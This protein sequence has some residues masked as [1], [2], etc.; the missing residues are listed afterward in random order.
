MVRVIV[1]SR[2]AFWLADPHYDLVTGRTSLLAYMAIPSL[3][4]ERASLN[5]SRHVGG[6]LSSQ[7]T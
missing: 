2:T 6:R 7:I 5:Y 4:L 1:H 3:K